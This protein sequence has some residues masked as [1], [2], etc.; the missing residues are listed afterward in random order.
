MRYLTKGDL[1]TL[2]DDEADQ[3]TMFMMD[4]A[5]YGVTG[6]LLTKLKVAKQ[7]FDWTGGLNIDLPELQK[8]IGLLISLGIISQAKKDAL[9]AVVDN[10]NLDSFTIYIKALDDVTPLNQT[11]AIQEGNFW[12]VS[13]QFKNVTKNT[14]LDELFVF[15]RMPT[16]QEVTETISKH[17]KMLRSNGE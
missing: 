12:K 6:D 14:I 4:P 5:S 7:K 10:P 15:D 8:L 13:A 2:L 9:D 3:F 17:I 16:I 11:G 1:L